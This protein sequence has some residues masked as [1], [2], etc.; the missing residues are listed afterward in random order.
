MQKYSVNQ[1]LINTLLSWVVSGEVAIPEIQRPFVWGSSKVRDLIDS[2][3]KGY[4]IGY[5]ITWKNPD[6]NLKDGTIS[7][8][9]K[10][11]IDG[12]QRLTAMRAAIL[13][14]AVIDKEYKES[15]IMISFN[16][17]TEEFMTQTPAI[18]KDKVWIPDI[19]EILSSQ[20]TLF[21]FVRGYIER[22]PNENQEIV[23]QNIDK[24]LQIKNR[25]IGVID[26][27]DALD[28]ETVTDIFVRINSAGVVLSQADFVMSKIAAN[29]NYNGSILRKCIDY[30]AHICEYPDFYKIIS[31]VDTEF[32]NTEYFPL[33]SWVKDENIDLYVPDYNDI[34]R[35]AFTSE[36]Q[37]GRL[38]DLVSL[39]S[40]RNF[41]TREFEEQIVEESFHKLSKGIVSFINETDFKRFIMIIK[42]AGF[43]NSSLIRSQ[44]VLNFAYILYQ[45]LRR[46]NYKPEDIETYV[47]KWFVLSILTKRYS[48]SPESIFDFDIKRSTNGNFPK[49]L[50]EIESA[51]L[52]EAFW[53]ASLVQSLNTSVSS[54]P[55]FNVYLASQVK[56]NDFGFLSKDITVN[57][58][59][60]HRGDIHHIFPKDYLKKLGLPQSMY[61]QIA[62]Y[63]Y[64][65]SEINIKVGNKSP[66][67]YFKDLESQIKNGE[68][69]YGGI[70]SEEDLSQNLKMNCIPEEV[71]SMTVDNYEEFLSMRRI[72]MAEKIKNYYMSL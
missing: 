32:V 21:S 62:N 49:F 26:L 11:I 13:G 54:S 61:N 27:E 31:E 35:V 17:I 16:P 42:S 6:T 41:E 53:N 9:R 44:N 59:I 65:Q 30:F 60:T 67:S 36:F 68:T 12:Q 34:V 19:S 7:R 3:Y 1:H 10:I 48:G 64:M 47:R 72:L 23:E 5:I 8:G 2:L 69:I 4:P 63:V 37:R 71:R 39:L 25:Q 29:E 14:M 43:I 51:N 22:N 56:S 20:N 70:T 18:V 24:L 55:Y 38:S 57:N 50:N 58:L 15:R 45:V 46:E 40:G 66:E 33:I 28:I 52:S